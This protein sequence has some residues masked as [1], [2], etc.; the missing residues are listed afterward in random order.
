M[1]LSCHD[2]EYTYKGIDK[3]H[4]CSRGKKTRYSCKITS[5]RRHMWVCERHRNENHEALES[6]KDEYQKNHRLTLGLFTTPIQLTALGQNKKRKVSTSTDNLVKPDKKSNPSIF[7]AS[8]TDDKDA[9]SKPVNGH[10][11]ISTVLYLQGLV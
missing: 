4:N 11:N 3:N 5:C 2:P 10:K 8:E 1:C 7:E 9:I 6:F